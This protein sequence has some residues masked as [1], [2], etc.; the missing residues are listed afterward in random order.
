MDAFIQLRLKRWNFC[1]NFS[2]MVPDEDDDITDSIY[3]TTVDKCAVVKME[4]DE[5][6]DSPIS[7]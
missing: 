3:D 6:L 2:C 4:P 7:P 1:K 5:S